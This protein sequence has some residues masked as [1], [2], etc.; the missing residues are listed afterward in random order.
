MSARR[1]LRKNAQILKKKAEDKQLESL[2][3]RNLMDQANFKSLS[4]PSSFL[5]IALQGNL[6]PKFDMLRNL[7]AKR[8]LVYISDIQVNEFFRFF[9]IYN[10]PYENCWFHR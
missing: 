2:P 10:E 7:A 4:E 9:T 6:K 5:H 1:I 8:H 3:I